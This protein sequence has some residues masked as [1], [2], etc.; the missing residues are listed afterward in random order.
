[1]SYKKGYERG[2]KDVPWDWPSIQ[3]MGFIFSLEGVVRSIL[4]SDV[5]D[6][7]FVHMTD[8]GHLGYDGQSNGS[9]K[10]RGSVGSVIKYY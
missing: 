4:S 8:P 9:R 3:Y 1:M 7:S 10:F 6:R 5:T 2:P